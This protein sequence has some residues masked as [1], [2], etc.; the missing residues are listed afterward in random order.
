MNIKNIEIIAQRDSNTYLVSFGND[1]GCILYL[2]EK[3]LS[4]P[5]LVDGILKFGYWDDYTGTINIEKLIPELQIETKHNRDLVA[6]KDQFP[7]VSNEREYLV[8]RQNDN[9]RELLFQEIKQGRLRQG[10]AYSNEFCLSQGRDSF[11]ESF[12]KESPNS[13]RIEAQKLWNVLSRMLQI[14]DGDTIVVPKQPKY[15][16]FLILRAMSKP[17]TNSCYSYE[18]LAG[19]ND[20]QHIIHIDPNEIQVVHYD[21]LLTPMIVKRLLKSIA[22]SS[23]VNSVKKQAFKEGIN[24]LVEV[25]DQKALAAANPLQSRVSASEQKLYQEWVKIMRE[26]TPSDFEKMVN[27]FMHGNGF[28]IRKRNSYDRQGGDIDLLCSKE[29]SFETPFDME[30]VQLIYCIQ[31]K[32]HSNLTNSDGV[33]QLIKMEKALDLK[34]TD[35]VQKLLISLSDGFTEECEKL[36]EENEVILIKGVE[37]A[38]KYFKHSK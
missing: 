14:K 27:N 19:V 16:Q 9:D 36:A 2:Q 28:T 10:W 12:L 3:I 8:F 38:E 18:P 32:K 11:I 34:E 29:V 24:E 17:G 4:Q 25:R 15:Q 23:P 33:H 13:T 31:I 22:Y 37:F 6:L 1:I 35:I 30:S 26:L 5:M 20:Y 7:Q 21:S